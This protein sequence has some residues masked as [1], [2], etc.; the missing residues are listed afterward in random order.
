[1]TQSIETLGEVVKVCGGAGEVAKACRVSPQAV[2][3]WLNKDSLPATEYTGKTEHA[4]TLYRLAGE[5]GH[6]IN[7]RWLLETFNPARVTKHGK[8]K[9]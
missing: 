7:H 1:M 3:K 2:Y 9:S 8:Q 6:Y 5:H 4:V